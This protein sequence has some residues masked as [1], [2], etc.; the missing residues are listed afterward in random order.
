MTLF[1]YHHAHHGTGLSVCR[2]T[3]L[4]ME[5][6]IEAILSIY[7]P[8]LSLLLSP[9]TSSLSSFLTSSSSSSFP[10]SLSS[11]T[12]SLSLSLSSSS[13]SLSLSSISSISHI[14][15]L[16]ARPRTSFS[17]TSFVEANILIFLSSNS[18]S[19]SLPIISIERVSGLVDE[20]KHLK[21]Q[22]NH[23]LDQFIEENRLKYHEKKSQNIASYKTEFSLFD[24][25]ECI[26]ET[27]DQ[28]NNG[29]CMICFQSLISPDITISNTNHN[30]PIA[31]RTSCYHCY[32]I[33]CLCQWACVYLEEIHGLEMKLEVEQN[34]MKYRSLQGDVKSAQTQL[35]KFQQEHD[36][37]TQQI[38][39]TVAK[40]NRLR[41]EGQSGEK[42]EMSVA[43]LQNQLAQV[44]SQIMK[45]TGKKKFKLVD[46]AERLK[47]QIQSLSQ[48][49]SSETV[50][51]LESKIS[52][53]QRQLAEVEGKMKRCQQ[54]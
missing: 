5:D 17:S 14:L 21:Q 52:A 25:I 34:E 46:T 49:E 31:L 26:Y 7:S 3:L 28:S 20:G 47:D 36:L 13:S 30:H 38:N 44:Q 15:S 9:S 2:V 53:G 39:E 50:G 41:G 18:S 54:R 11:L 24:L 1:K 51:Q 4:K 45:A 35:I 48:E 19:F 33:S 16:I 29:D 10:L 6:E 42:G 22:I 37:L 32:H 12:S 23:Y 27:L 40:L 43:E 8:D